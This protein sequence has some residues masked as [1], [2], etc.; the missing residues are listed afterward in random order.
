MAFQV[1]GEGPGLLVVGG[2]ACMSVMW[3]DPTGSVFLTELAESS[4]LVTFDQR[5]ARR[6]DPLTSDEPLP[7]EERVADALAV[8]DAAAVQQADVL[9]TH[10]GGPVALLAVTADPGRFRSLTLVNTAP[11]MAWATD[12]PQGHRPCGRGLVRR[13]AER[14]VGD[15]LHDGPLAPSNCAIAAHVLAAGSARDR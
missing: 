9:A 1:A 11:R 15:G 6:S 13:G 14:P 4:R 8:L 2:A 12:Y 10:D 7:L 5:G 3:E